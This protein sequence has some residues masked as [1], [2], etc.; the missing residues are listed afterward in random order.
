MKYQKCLY[1][2]KPINRYSLYHLF[3]E[4]DKLCLECRRRLGF[5]IRHFKLDGLDVEYFYDYDSLYKTLLLQYK[6]CYDEALRDVF[7]YKADVYI[8]IRY[9]GYKIIYVPSSQEKLNKRGFDHLKEIFAGLGFKEVKGLKTR[10]DLIQEGK[11]FEERQKMIGNYFYEGEY[12]KKLLIVDDVLTSGASLKA[13][14]E[15]M[16]GHCGK[17]KALILARS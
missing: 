7:L 5:R 2:D 1:C 17:M 15:A 14:K 8:R 13:V 3:I 4:E 16:K 6:E 10:Q 12:V 9:S 11:N